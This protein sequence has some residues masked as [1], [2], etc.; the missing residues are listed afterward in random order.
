VYLL[1]HTKEDPPHSFSLSYLCG[2]SSYKAAFGSS[3]ADLCN[4]HFSHITQFK[5][6][7]NE[8]QTQFSWL[9]ISTC[10]LLFTAIVWPY[11]KD[12][13]VIDNRESCTVPENEI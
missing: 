2:F 3:G 9:W 1:W 8:T 13:M 4:I 6:G 11:Q 7:E 12:A 5:S 10:S